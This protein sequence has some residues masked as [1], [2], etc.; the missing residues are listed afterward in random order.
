MAEK[1]QSQPARPEMAPREDNVYSAVYHA[2]IYGM[3]A[4]SALFLAGM[5]LALGRHE[6][7]PLTTTWVRSQMQWHVFW[8]GLLHADPTALLLLATVLLILT[9]VS[10][11]VIS[12]YAFTVDRDWPYVLVTSVVLGVIVLT[13]ILARFGLK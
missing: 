9:P 2:L 3:Y 7:V 8:P 5:L 4:S 11:V 10:R 1:T 12:I 13:V 6:S